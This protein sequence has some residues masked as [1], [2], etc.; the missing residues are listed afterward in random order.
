MMSK[1]WLFAILGLLVSGLALAATPVLA[2]ASAVTSPGHTIGAAGTLK[3]NSAVS[4]G[5]GRID[6]W[7]VP[8]YG[9]DVVQL[10]VS[11]PSGN[12]FVFALYPPGTTDRNFASAVPVSS[13]TVGNPAQDSDLTVP[14]NGTYVLAVCENVANNNCVNAVAGTGTNPMNKYKILPSLVGGGVSPKVAAKETRASRT[15]A[16]AKSTALGNF[17]SGGGGPID[18]WK[19]PLHG[20]DV[21]QLAVSNPSSNVFVFALYPPGTTDRNFASAAPVSSFTIGNPAQDSDLAAP[22]NGTYVLA[23]CE[24]VANNNC[25]NAVEG[26]GTNPMNEYTFTPTRIGGHESKT[27]LRLS[28]KSVTYGH[29]KS[30]KFSVTVTA[31]YGGSVTGKV[32][33]SDGKKTVCTIKLSKGKGSCTLPSSKTLAPGKYKMTASYV[34]NKA[35]SKSG[36]SVLTVKK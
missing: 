25:V 27:S 15:I 35:P 30:E 4:G 10:A 33:V 13:F 32:N 28:A 24:N 17:E 11:N 22:H 3:I 2:S 36:T 7:K 6:Y 12:V 26:T 19:V 23:V 9:G 21:V 1:L 14:Y 20:G 8:L 34:G 5:G 16:G 31:V 29:E 18:Y